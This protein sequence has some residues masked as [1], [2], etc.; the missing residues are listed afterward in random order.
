ML[1]ERKRR[2]HLFISVAVAI[3]GCGLTNLVQAQFTAPLG[4]TI[5]TAAG[6]TVITE[7][8]PGTAQSLS[9]TWGIAKDSSGNIYIAVMDR[10]KIFKL[11]PGGILTTFAGNGQ[12]GS[13]GDGGPAT[14]A[15][16]NSP[17]GVAVDSAGN[18]YIADTSN[19]RVRKV[20]AAT[21]VIST[22]AGTG[23]FGVTGD[24]GPG[25]LK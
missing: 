20:T 4:Y 18:V 2:Y 19:G 23:S 1:V 15:Q 25:S 6:P 14:S 10:H 22:I 3:L 12:P 7:G 5:S 11:T 21:G 8:G 17:Q 24:G 13:S 16:L 9:P